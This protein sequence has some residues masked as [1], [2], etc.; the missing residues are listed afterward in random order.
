MDHTYDQSAQI[1]QYLTM[2]FV[3]GEKMGAK[4]FFTGNL[5]IHKITLT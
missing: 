2:G 1:L 4:K 3:F 5:E